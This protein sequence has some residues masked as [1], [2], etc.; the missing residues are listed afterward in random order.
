MS[1]GTHAAPA[2]VL[3]VEDEPEMQVILRDNLEF[4]GHEALEA[5]SGEAAVELA[6]RERPD[7]VLL[8]LMLPRMS[9]YE[10]CRQLRDGGLL[11]PIIMITARNGEADR[12]LGLEL[13]ADDYVG[14][15]FSV[16]EVMTRV[17]V[18]LRRRGGEAERELDQ[19]SFGEITVDLRRHQV[20][21]R[22]RSVVLSGREFELL[23]YF[24]R[25]KDELVSREQLLRDVW[26]YTNMPL[27][28][29]VDNFV[30][31]LRR[32]IERDPQNPR[33]ILTLYGVGYRFIP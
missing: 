23:R 30:A 9:G 12:I 6:F 28:R 22:S 8:D 10:V 17:R 24:V 26:G 2:R 1:N 15:P 19:F 4:E 18:H 25:H 20:R 21:R 7:L 29:T 3:V 13:G 11:M 32:K 16:R 14:K 27:T 33:H 31:K 5:A